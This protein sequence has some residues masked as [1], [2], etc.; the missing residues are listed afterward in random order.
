MRV[1]LRPAGLADAAALL[2]IKDR[3]RLKLE[4]ATSRQLGGF[5]LGTSLVEY[6]QFIRRDVVLVAE[7]DCPQQ[8]VGF[9]IV[10]QHDT[11]MQSELLKRAE[12]V[13]WEA[14]FRQRF[15]ARRM[16]FFEQLGMLPDA[17]YRVYAKYLAFS[18][19]WQVLQTH[20]ALFTTVLQYPFVN[21]A[22]LSFIKVV[23]FEYVGVV[24]EVY[25]DYGRIKSDVYHLER[26]IFE[27]KIDQPRF[28][29]FLERARQAGYW[30]Q[31]N[32]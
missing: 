28:K 13:Q 6:E 19:T 18:I 27:R 30:T 26:P 16:A 1:A 23:G 12:Q 11:L 7:S 5:L 21:T 3:I 2:D 25:P 32:S 31:E 15:D 24:D 17:A 10:M 22:A 29:I 9:A 4:S 14:A 20:E 8:V